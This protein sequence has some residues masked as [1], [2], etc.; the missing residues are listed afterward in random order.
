M[1]CFT[2]ESVDSR[3]ANPRANLPGRQ[4][5]VVHC[6][7]DAILDLKRA[8]GFPLNPPSGFPLN[9]SEKNS[10]KGILY[11]KKENLISEESL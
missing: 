5:L 8:F 4:D 10:T 1:S 7:A 11:A 6:E 3:V 2:P 9:R